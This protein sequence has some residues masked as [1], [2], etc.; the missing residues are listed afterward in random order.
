[1]SRT[2]GMGGVVPRQ[3][4]GDDE[5]PVAAAAPPHL[6]SQ[7][8]RRATAHS[9][10]ARGRRSGGTNGAL[11]CVAAITT[12]LLLGAS[13]TA[14]ANLGRDENCVPNEAIAPR[15]G[16]CADF[17]SYGVSIT[18]NSTLEQRQNDA[19]AAYREL[20]WKWGNRT[21]PLVTKE[22]LSFEA[23]YR[24]VELIP[25]CDDA[26]SLD[27]C[28][29]FC[30]RRARR[31]KTEEESCQVLPEEDCSSADTPSWTRRALTA[32]VASTV[33]TVASLLASSA[34]SGS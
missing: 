23:H 16:Y 2:R 5:S 29:S 7:R 27:L 13:H 24:C 19:F 22:C 30:Q 28:Q 9:N 10:A 32:L 8:H 11:L 12:F 1:M 14:D 6:C 15:L 26:R 25:A 33:W 31:C 21:L 18:V 20:M 17:V 34:V 3:C 4:G